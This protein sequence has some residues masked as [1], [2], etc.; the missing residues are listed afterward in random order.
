M[1]NVFKTFISDET[2]AVTVDW[3]VL[4][5]AL[6]GLC[7]AIMSSVGEGTEDLTTDI[8]DQLTSQLISTT[9]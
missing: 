6:I 2:G 7:L 1:K 8:R 5:A 3:V 4:A 9:F